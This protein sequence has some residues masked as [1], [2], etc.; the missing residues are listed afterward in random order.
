MEPPRYFKQFIGNKSPCGAFYQMGGV[1]KNKYI[2]DEKFYS[3]VAEMFDPTYLRCIVMNAEDYFTIATDISNGIYKEYYDIRFFP[4]DFL[5]YLQILRGLKDLENLSEDEQDL[6]S[7]VKTFLPILFNGK[8]MD[9]YDVIDLYANNIGLKCVPSSDDEWIINNKK[10][11][12]TYYDASK[13]DLL[14]VFVKQSTMIY[15]I[16]A[17]IGDLQDG[18]KLNGAHGTIDLVWEQHEEYGKH[19]NIVKITQAET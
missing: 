3:M 18:I 8:P 6:Y 1:V 2:E 11:I 16:N 13:S 12:L 7:L 17:Y 15:G 4:I 9:I 5:D 14:D 19:K 10:P